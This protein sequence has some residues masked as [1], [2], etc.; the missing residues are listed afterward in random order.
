MHGYL[1]FAFSINLSYGASNCAKLW[2]LLE[3]VK[4]YLLL[5]FLSVDIEMDSNVL[6]SWLQKA[7]CGIWY[8]KDYWEEFQKLLLAIDYIVCHTYR[9]GNVI[10]DWLARFDAREGDAEWLNMRDLPHMLHGL[11]REDKWVLPTIWCQGQ[12]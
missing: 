5:N 6:L 2:A 4:H 1:L 9:E 11:L 8:L 10:A 7:R 3:G 12:A